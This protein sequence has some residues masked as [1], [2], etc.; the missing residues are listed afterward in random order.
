MAAA[1][2]GPHGPA[3]GTCS[4]AIQ[5]ERETMNANSTCKFPRLLP[6]TAMVH[7]SHSS[8]RG[9]SELSLAGRVLR[10]AA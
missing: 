5:R 4:P 9:C 8:R 2:A 6:G 7:V 1:V 10:G 3:N